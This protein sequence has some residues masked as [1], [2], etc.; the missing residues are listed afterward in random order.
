[1]SSPFTGGGSPPSTT[2]M[3][4]VPANPGWWNV[5]GTSDEVKPEVFQM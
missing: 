2:L 5:I 3:H 4:L 1:M